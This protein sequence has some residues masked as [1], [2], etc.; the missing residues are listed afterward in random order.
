MSESTVIQLSVSIKGGR[1]ALRHLSTED[2]ITEL[3][4]FGIEVTEEER[5][6]FKGKVFEF[7]IS[8]CGVN[9]KLEVNF[10]C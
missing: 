3:F 8:V 7:L 5:S 2:L 10:Y 6:K 4:N 9:S 1:M